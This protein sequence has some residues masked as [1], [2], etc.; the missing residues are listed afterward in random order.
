MTSTD[1]D[2]L[3]LGQLLTRS[4]NRS[5]SI[6]SAPSPNDS[7]VQQLLQA[8][9]ADLTLANKLIQHLAVLSP[10]ETLD[11]INTNDLRCILVDA[12][13]GQLCLLA[14][15]KGGAERVKYLTRAQNH[16]R[17]YSALVEQYEVV[18]QEERKAYQGVSA[19]EMDAG[20]RRAGKIAQFKREKE[21]KATLDE[22]RKRRK[23]RSPRKTTLAVS[24]NTASSSTSTSSPAA[25][26]ADDFL[27]EDDD[28]SD[29]VARPLLLSLLQLHYLRAHAELS[30]IEQELELLEHGMKMSEIP[31]PSP[32]SASGS[33][34][35]GDSRRDG[36]TNDDDA[37]DT[38]WRLDKLSLSTDAPLLS[39]EGKVL[40]PFTILPSAKSGSSSSQLHTRLR[41]QSEVFQSSHRLPTMTIDE[42]LDEQNA[43]GNVLQGGGPSTSAEVDQAR[44]DE[45]AEKE[46]DTQRGLDAE[47]RELYKTREF[48]EYR[49]THRKGEGNISARGDDDDDSRS[50]SSFEMHEL[51]HRRI[52]RKLRDWRETRK[53]GT[54]E[55]RERERKRAQEL[56]S[57]RFANH[58]T[59]TLVP[60]DAPIGEAT[61]RQNR[62]YLRNL[63]SFNRYYGSRSRSGSNSE[64]DSDGRGTYSR[65][66]GATTTSLPRDRPSSVQS[67]ERHPS[68]I[69]ALP[70][71]ALSGSTIRTTSLR[72]IMS[73]IRIPVV[74]AIRPLGTPRNDIVGQIE[75]A[76]DID[77]CHR[78]TA[79][80]RDTASFTEPTTRN[81]RAS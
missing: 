10:N 20:K 66:E 73:S 11:D 19:G 2:D 65:D 22:L 61:E 34:A 17:T 46:D 37:E 14:R 36:R 18:P 1:Q 29:D 4:I 26:D 23:E 70:T 7:S 30:S 33:T 41:L 25:D 56:V 24:S 63:R 3:T 15:T 47:E 62:G 42:Y 53:G 39:P 52:H 48:D 31:S 8:T 9:L 32:H 68:T 38:T 6:T 55:H 35:N 60:S 58:G 78:G 44:R 49:D 64:N 57:E 12:L 5:T 21:I 71:P 45:Q 28:E 69:D 75:K 74:M 13:S 80:S 27:D 59:A 79:T 50:V 40:R 76:A 81:E 43:M 72:N 54:D 67:A 51:P 16:F 77:L